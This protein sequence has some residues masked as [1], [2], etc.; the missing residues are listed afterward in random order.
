MIRQSISYLAAIT[1]VVA[2]LADLLLCE[3]D[4]ECGRSGGRPKRATCGSI[5]NNSVRVARWS[6]RLMV[7][8]TYEAWSSADPGLACRQA[9]LNIGGEAQ[10]RAHFLRRGEARSVGNG[11]AVG[12]LRRLRRLEPQAALGTGKRP[13]RLGWWRRSRRRRGCGR[14]TWVAPAAARL[15]HAANVGVRLNGA[16]AA[17]RGGERAERG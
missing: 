17:N 9:D 15:H 14:R 1:V 5:S 10:V 2:E 13:R 6:R 8:R 7:V 16:L 11:S 4:V 3:V 12:R